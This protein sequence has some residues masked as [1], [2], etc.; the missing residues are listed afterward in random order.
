MSPQHGENVPAT[1]RKCSFCSFRLSLGP[2]GTSV[3][4]G[5]SPSFETH[6]FRIFRHVNSFWTCFSKN[7]FV[8]FMAHARGQWSKVQH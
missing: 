3:S 4:S 8:K 5:I 7:G 6:F 1:R 2:L